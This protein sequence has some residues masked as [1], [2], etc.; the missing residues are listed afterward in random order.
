MNAACVVEVGKV[1]RSVVA[2]MEA[3]VILM[4]GRVGRGSQLSLER[5]TRG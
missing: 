2:E 1:G 3:R 4:G 5:D